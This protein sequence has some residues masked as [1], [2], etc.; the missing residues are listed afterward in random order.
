MDPV[1]PAT[2][3][4]CIMTK[5]LREEQGFDGIVMTDCMEMDAIRAFYG[6]GEGAVLA[7][8][9]GCD[10]ILFS[11]T[12]EA[13]KQAVEALYDAV[14]SGRLSVERIEESYNRIKMCIRDSNCAVID[15]AMEA[16]KRGAL[17]V[18]ITSLEHARHV[19]SRHSSGYKLHEVCDYEMCIRDRFT[20]VQIMT[21]GGPGYSTTTIVTYLYQKGF[22]EY[23]MGMALS[24]I[25]I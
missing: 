1:Y 4:K 21:N 18:A 10:M 6:I 24:L 15:A 11:H 2:L 20:P 22:Q 13:V 23:K 8:E 14:E 17:T 25:H 7:V 3:S 9:A 16:K 5:I 12:F 19:T